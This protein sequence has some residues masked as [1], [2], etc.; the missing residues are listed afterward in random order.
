MRRSAP[1][2]AACRRHR[3]QT[4]R[5]EREVLRLRAENQELREEVGRLQQLLE[6]ERRATKRQAAPFSKGEPKAAPK[7]PGRKAGSRYGRKAH[8]PPP[9]HVDQELEAPLP[10]EC[11]DCG[12]S[13]EPL[14][15]ADQYQTELPPIRPHVTRFRVAI[16][17]CRLCSRRVQ[18]RHPQQTSNA[19]GAAAS[20]IGPRAQAVAAHLNK[21][22]GLS[23][24]KTRRVLQDVFGISVTRGGW[25]QAIARVGRTAEPTWEALRIW[26]R[27]A[28]VVIPDETGWKVGGRL[29][30]LWVFVTPE[31]TVYAILPGRGFEQACQVLDADYDGNLARDGWAP[32]R[33]FVH[34]T[35]Q[36]CLGHLLRRCRGILETAQRGG[37]RF[38]RAVKRILQ[39]AL[40][41]RDR[42]DAGSIS[43]HGL[44]VAVG[45][46]EAR[47]DRLLAWTPKVEANRKLRKH[48]RQ[49]RTALFTFLRDPRVPATNWPAEQAIRPAVVTR[50]V[51]GG[52]RTWP[53]AH[54]H[55]VLAS[56]MRTCRQ[57]KMDPLPLLADL[58]C[59]PDLRVAQELAPSW[60]RAK[61][62]P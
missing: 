55:E 32:Y 24:G 62:V 17:R 34:A 5:L 44:A 61:G 29:Q 40:A 8:R 11:P 28:P 49:E 26:V 27:Q 10:P 47:M 33:K 38:P 25:S 59:S 20:Q 6:A 37:A 7:R 51:W 41:L 16:G 23:F 48:L 9:E 52:N 1:P 56:L 58:L 35:H 30:W 18:G 39:Q 45:R 36:T 19:L 43:P 4:R 13:L 31:V 22:L 42:R 15:V 14:E 21:E 12:G 57:Q 54:T 46:L 50:K 2:C 53:G 60:A 3:R